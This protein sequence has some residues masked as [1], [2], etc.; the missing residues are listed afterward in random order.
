MRSFPKPILGG[1]LI[2][3]LTIGCGGQRNGGPVQTPARPG[4]ATM[5]KATFAGGCFWC[6][7]SDFEK[8]DGVAAVVSGYAGGTGE[9]PSYRDYMNT[10]RIEVVQVEY[11]PSETTYAELLDVFWRHIDPTDAGGQFVDR[12]PHYRSAIFYD[13]E[14]QKQEAEKSKEKLAASG[15]FDKPIVTDI[16]PLVKFYSAE[17]YHQ[18]FYKKS[19]TRYHSYRAS[20][21]RDAFLNGVWG[22][23][24]GSDK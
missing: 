15:K 7:E 11:D 1:L 14:A 17:E 12:G 13:N 24:R 6:V 3:V 10:G 21:G 8:V 22:A 18:D 19:P 5:E 2:L 23:N 20:S 16:L 4:G 9:D